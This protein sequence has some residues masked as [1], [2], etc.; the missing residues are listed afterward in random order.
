MMIRN[1]LAKCII[2][3]FIC[4]SLIISILSVPIIAAGSAE[5]VEKN[6][7]K[8][9]LVEFKDPSVGK[10]VEKAVKEKLKLPKL[11]VKKEL[12]TKKITVYEIGET[13]NIKKVIEE[14]KKSKQ[15]EFVQE[16]FLLRPQEIPSDTRFSDQW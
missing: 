1:R 9:I 7:Q 3:A 14:F 16:D 4:T 15:V 12:K 8:R 11:K 10:N 6:L 5:E 2:S 13:D